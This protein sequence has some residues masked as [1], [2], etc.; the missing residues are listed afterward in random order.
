MERS[1]N[2]MVRGD[3]FFLIWSVNEMVCVDSLTLVREWNGPWR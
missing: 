2:G 1:V 3:S